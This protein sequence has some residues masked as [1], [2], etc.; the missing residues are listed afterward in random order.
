MKRPNLCSAAALAFRRQCLHSRA[1]TTVEFA[2]PTARPRSSCS[3]RSHSDDGWRATQFLYTM[4]DETHTVAARN[5]DG[6][7][8]R[9][10]SMRQALAVGS[11]TGYTNYSRRDGNPHTSRPSPE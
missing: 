11:L 6:D 3:I 10:V 8:W 2:A 9:H 4:D 7:L 5:P 1:R